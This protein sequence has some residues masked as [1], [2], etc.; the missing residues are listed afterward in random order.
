MLKDFLPVSDSEKAVSEIAFVEKFWTDQLESNLG[1]LL[2]DELAN[3]EEY[4]IMKQYLK[5]LTSKAKIL[6]GG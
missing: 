1:R 4:L 2:E 5:S 6:D 3:R